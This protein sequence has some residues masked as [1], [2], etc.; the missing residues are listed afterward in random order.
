MA[1]RQMQNGPIQRDYFCLERW[2]TSVFALV[3]IIV[4]K[5]AMMGK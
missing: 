3:S 2:M 1:A 4:L 5:E